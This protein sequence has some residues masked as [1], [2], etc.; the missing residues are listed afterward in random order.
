[1]RENRP[2]WKLFWS[3]LSRIRAEYGEIL[4][5]YSVRMRENVDE[6]NSEYGHFLRSKSL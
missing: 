4:R 1:M 2:Y 5:Q 6:N 3:A